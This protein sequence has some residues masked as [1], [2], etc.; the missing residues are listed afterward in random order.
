MGIKL[1]KWGKSSNI[2]GIKILPEGT[3]AHEI[4]L[5]VGL[6]TCSYLPDWTKYTKHDKTLQFLTHGTFNVRK[7]DFLR[8]VMNDRIPVPCARQF[9]ALNRWEQLSNEKDKGR[10]KV[11][12]Q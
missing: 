6:W 9:E 7:L 1:S 3:D 11:R 8:Q 10:F 12:F 4:M 2:E 5:K